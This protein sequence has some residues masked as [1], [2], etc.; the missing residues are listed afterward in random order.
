MQKEKL[1]ES[2]YVDLVLAAQRDESRMNYAA[3]AIMPYAKWFV[4]KY[5][6][7]PADD[8]Y[9]ILIAT[10]PRAIRGYRESKGEWKPYMFQAMYRAMTSERKKMYAKKRECDKFPV[11]IDAHPAIEELMEL[12][13]DAKN[14][15]TEEN[16]GILEVAMDALG[17]EDR[18]LLTFRYYDKFTLNQL[19]DMYGCSR[20]TISNRC[21]D[22]I[23]RLRELFKQAEELP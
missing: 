7:Q 15:F 4:N 12:D 10:I 1:T 18:V 2:D 6:L 14:I 20:Q 22:A 5:E 19:G 3:K 8:W 11:Y 23:G 21:Q 13:V 17:N 9:S 16:F